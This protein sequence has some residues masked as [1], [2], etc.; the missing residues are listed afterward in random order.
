M[1]ETQ[2][3]LRFAGILTPPEFDR[4][5][6]MRLDLEMAD[7]CRRPLDADDHGGARHGWPAIFGYR[8]RH[9]SGRSILTMCPPRL[10][11]EA[12][13]DPADPHR[14]RPYTI[15][16]NAPALFPLYEALVAAGRLRDPGHTGA[17]PAEL[18]D[19]RRA[20]QEG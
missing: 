11:V 8:W 15:E 13:R 19:E 6:D 3:V 9:E 5:R 20:P 16:V 14:A 1:T 7:S 4:A 17:A 2:P 10:S 12:E 18:V